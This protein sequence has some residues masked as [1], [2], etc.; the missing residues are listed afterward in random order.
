[1]IK[2]NLTSGCTKIAIA[3]VIVFLLHLSQFFD[4]LLGHTR[5]QGKC[6][7]AIWLSH[8]P[9]LA[10]RAVYEE[11]SGL[12]IGGQHGRWFV[13][14]CY[15]HRPQ[16]LM[17]CSSVLHS[18]ASTLKVVQALR[19]PLVIHPVRHM[20]LLSDEPMSCS[21]ASTNGFLNLIYSAFAPGG[22]VSAEWSRCPGSIARHARESVAPLQF[23][24]A[25]WMPARMGR[26]STGVGRKHPL[27]I[28]NAS[29]MAR[30]MRWVWALWHQT[31][32]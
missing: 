19:L 30:S 3:K 22:W 17:V 2:Q 31:G 1:M 26:L 18:Q 12:D 7:A 15:T 24:S 13:L 20:L 25:G 10:G 5:S 23:N 11:V 16:G 32:A 21:A 6:W 4:P 14:L 28:C 9:E 29:L 27:I 8:H